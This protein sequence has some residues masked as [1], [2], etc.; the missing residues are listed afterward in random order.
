MSIADQ[1]NH[2]ICI[3]SHAVEKAAHTFLHLKLPMYDHIS[4]S[5]AAQG[6]VRRELVQLGDASAAMLRFD[7][8]LPSDGMLL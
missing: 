8:A 3:N 7:K 2:G 1:Q 4:L 6:A 5:W